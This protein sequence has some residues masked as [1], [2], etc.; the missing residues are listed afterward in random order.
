M[1]DILINLSKET[2]TRI[3]IF[4]NSVGDGEVRVTANGTGDGTGAMEQTRIVSVTVITPT[5]TISAS[6]SVLNIEADQ[7]PTAEL[8]VRVIA[9][10]GTPNDVTLTA[11]IDGDSRVASVTPTEIIVSANAPTMF[12]VEGLVTGNVTL[13]LTASH[14]DYISADTTM[15]TVNVDRPVEELRFRIKVFLEGAAQ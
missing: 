2:S 4:G 1:S 10:A 5:L 15:I 13:T 12:I 11:M 9:E 8:T 3:E 6:T 7:P 14:S